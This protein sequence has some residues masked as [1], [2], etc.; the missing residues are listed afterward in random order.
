V[1]NGLRE[2]I[3]TWD[4]FLDRLYVAALQC[5]HWNASQRDASVESQAYEQRARA[6]CDFGTPA[7]FRKLSSEFGIELE[8]QPEIESIKKARNCL[9][10]RL[11]LVKGRDANS[12]QGLRVMWR[13]PELYGVNADGSEFVPSLESFPI[14]FPVDSPV[15]HR[16]G[17]RERMVAIGQRLELAAA[18][19]KEICYT[20]R[21]AIMQAQE[22]FVA[23]VTRMGGTFNTSDHE[24]RTPAP[25]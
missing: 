14:D 16:H 4:V 2:L 21:I 8:F 20:F 10:H 24:T 15:M 3:E 11:G 12:E 6:F 17:T 25:E 5:E 9:T 13:A 19:L 18:E 22:S 7:K 1:S 23:L